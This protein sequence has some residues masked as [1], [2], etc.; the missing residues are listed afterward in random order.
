[1]NFSFLD[2]CIA[3]NFE[4]WGRDFE[5]RGLDEKGA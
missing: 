2:K 4:D 1:V 3:P 5:K